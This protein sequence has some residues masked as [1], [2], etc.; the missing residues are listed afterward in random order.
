[1]PERITSLDVAHGVGNPAGSDLREVEHFGDEEG[2]VPLIGFD[3][4]EID[5]L[6]VG[7][8]PAQ[9]QVEELDVTTYCIEWRAQLVAH[10]AEERCLRPVRGIGIVGE[11][12]LAQGTED[13]LLGN[14]PL[15][16]A[17]GVGRARLADLDAESLGPPVVADHGPHIALPTAR[18][19]A[20]RID[21]L[22]H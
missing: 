4:R 2:E 6:L 18:S 17:G 3:A 20:R 12:A 5:A 22:I 8:G 1:V 21:A 9:S 7:H 11:T 13:T 16:V 15:K 10:G 14:L 19:L